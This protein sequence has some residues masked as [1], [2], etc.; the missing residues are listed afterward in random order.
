MLKIEVR[1]KGEIDQRWAEWFGSLSLSHSAAGETLLSG[2]VPDQAALY[3]IIARLRD[4]G[5][6]LEAV[7]SEEAAEF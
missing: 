2:L 7:K 6:E 3:G 1:I 5:M 4:L